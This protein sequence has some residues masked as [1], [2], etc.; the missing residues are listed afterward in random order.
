[1]MTS[2]S[3]KKPARRLPP[4]L[5]LLPYSLPDATQLKHIARTSLGTAGQAFSDQCLDQLIRKFEEIAKQRPEKRRAP[6]NC[7]PGCV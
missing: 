4:P 1:M 7:W 5:R 3:E 2:N 6:P